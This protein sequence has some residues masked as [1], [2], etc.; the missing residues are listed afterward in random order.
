MLLYTMISIEEDNKMHMERFK[1]T[2]PSPSYIAG[3]IDGDGCIFI[4]KIADGYQSGLQISQCRTNILQVI[5]HHFGGSITTSNI[6]NNKTESIEYN[7]P[8][9]KYNIRNQYNLI[10]RSNEYQLILDYIRYSFVIKQEQL[11]FLYEFNKIVNLPNRLDDKDALFTKCSANNIE[12]IVNPNNFSKINFEYIAGLFDAEG[13]VYINNNNYSKYYISISQK[14]HPLILYEIQK[15]MGFGHVEREIDYVIYKKIDC[16]KFLRRIRECLIVKYNQV[17]WF[18]RFLMTDDISIK[19]QSYIV[20][21]YEKHAVEQFIDLNQNDKGKEVFNETC[22]LRNIKQNMCKQINI[23]GVYKEK[24]ERMMG[25]NNHNYGKR[26]SQETKNKMSESI[27]KSKNGID[28]A[29]IIQVRNL[30]SNGK[31]NIEIQKLLNLPRHTVTNIKTGRIVCRDETKQIIIPLTPDE[32]A[33]SKRKITPDE[34][35]TVIEKCICDWK[36]TQILNYLVADRINKNIPNT[37]TVDI[38]KN[39]RRRLNAKNRLIYES[40]LSEDRYQY[41]T[42][43]LI[44]YDKQA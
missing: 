30:I 27:R 7:G 35:I 34:I 37:L 32:V 22:C 2:P 3:F 19:K 43:L 8:I 10:I 5:R 44:E 42:K 28:D 17:I 1:F 14:N 26:F 25:E 16:L 31:T 20:C 4:R 23:I 41:Y 40:E 6:R 12:T 36:P 18:E 38:V 15:F 24:S 29:T 33:L 13:C 39:I 11:N 21:N 9:H